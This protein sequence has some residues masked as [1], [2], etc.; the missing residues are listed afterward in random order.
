[1]RRRIDLRLFQGATATQALR[2]LGCCGLSAAA[3][4]AHF[5]SGHLQPDPGLVIAGLVDLLSTARTE[6]ERSAEGKEAPLTAVNQ[7]HK[8]RLE[9]IKLI[10]EIAETSQSESPRFTGETISMLLS[11][12]QAT[13]MR[14]LA[15]SRTRNKVK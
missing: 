11:D 4:R 13:E 12:Q 7:A 14:R 9:S 6:G 3:V 8:L 2:S 5:E 10:A 1:M 15:A